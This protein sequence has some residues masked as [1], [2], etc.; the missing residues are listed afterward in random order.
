VGQY[1]D[2]PGIPQHGYVLNHTGFVA[3]DVPGAVRSTAFDINERGDIV[4]AY[5]GADGTTRLYLFSS[6]VFTTI[7]VPGALGTL[8]TGIEL[9]LGFA[10]VLRVNFTWPTDFDRIAN[11]TGFELFIGYNY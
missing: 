9:N 6:D 10:P 11:D 2:T 8:G 1:N 5:V 4:G 7:D 3:I